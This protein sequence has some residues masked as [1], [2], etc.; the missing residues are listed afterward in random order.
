MYRPRYFRVEELVPPEIYQAR[1]DQAIELM[2]ERVLVTL[3]L[4]RE[5][6]GSCVVNDWCF[7]GSYEQSGLRTP[8][9]PEYSYTSQHSFGRAADCKF[10]NTSAH[11]ARQYVIR[12]K[13]R[14]K[15]ISFLEDD[16]DW[17]HFDV[18]NTRPILL[19]SAQT[20]QSKVV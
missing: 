6:F 18:R 5:Q 8:D 14:F 20:G 15:L 16:V 10:Y 1:G 7:G 2:D 4:L 3:D 11:D 17:F 12:N 13:H 19:W 9:A